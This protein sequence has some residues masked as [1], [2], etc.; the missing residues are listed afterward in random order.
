MSGVRMLHFLKRLIKINSN[1]PILYYGFKHMLSFHLNS[2]WTVLSHSV[3]LPM[4]D[5]LGVIW[6]FLID[7]RLSGSMW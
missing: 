4:V 3:N 2:P 6:V 7:V 1:P 5:F